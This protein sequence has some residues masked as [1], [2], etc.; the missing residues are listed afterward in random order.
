MTAQQR[1]LRPTRRRLRAWNYR[2]SA[3]GR[4]YWQL[5]S[6]RPRRLVRRRAS[7]NT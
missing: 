2:Q 7:Q 6:A 4:K 1:G 5:E 3:A